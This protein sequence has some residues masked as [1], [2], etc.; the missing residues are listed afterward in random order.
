MPYGRRQSRAAPGQFASARYLRFEIP[1]SDRGWRRHAARLGAKTGFV[2]AEISTPP[3]RTAAARRTRGPVA[4]GRPARRRRRRPPRPRPRPF[5][6][7]AAALCSRQPFG[8]PATGERGP[9]GA[10]AFD[11]RPGD[12]A[13]VATPGAKS[14]RN[15]IRPN[16]LSCSQPAQ[17]T[18]TGCP[19]R[20][21]HRTAGSHPRIQNGAGDERRPP[22]PRRLPPAAHERAARRDRRRR[23]P[24]RAQDARG[25]VQP[26]RHA[27]LQRVRDVRGSHRT[28]GRAGERPR[29]LSS[30]GDERGVHRDRTQA[31]GLRFDV[32]AVYGPAATQRAVFEGEAAP[33]CDAAVDDGVTGTLLAYGQTGAGKTF[34]VL[35]KNGT[36]SG[37]RYDDRGPRI[38]SGDGAYWF[39]CSSRLQEEWRS[40]MPTLQKS[41]ETV[42]VSLAESSVYRRPRPAVARARLPAGRAAPARGRGRRRAVVVLR[43]G[44]RRAAF[45]D[46]YP[47]TRAAAATFERRRPTR[48]NGLR[49]SSLKFGCR[50]ARRSTTRRSWIC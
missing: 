15:Q 46:G 42:L 50:C 45:E 34:T 10:R 7:D 36:A 9:I 17:R 37:A 25:R 48:Q 12:G 31:E 8:A 44:H 1:A 2:L 40:H 33:L 23:A 21:P 18:R 5:S 26:A 47:P 11:A 35:G 28:R 30:A 29:R 22:H 14:R 39:L 4:T 49:V 41:A 32:D 3:R 27:G 13:A 16:S 20:A 43:G 38:P 24:H 19:V 6:H